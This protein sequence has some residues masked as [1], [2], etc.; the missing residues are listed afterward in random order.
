MDELAFGGA[1]D[2]G[3][4]GLPGDAIEIEGEQ[5][6]VQAQPRAGDGR[7]TTGMAAADHDHVEGFGGVSGEAHGFIIRSR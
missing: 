6:G 1:T 4:A 5:G 3:V 2:G 7:F